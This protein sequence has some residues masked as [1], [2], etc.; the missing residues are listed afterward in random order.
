MLKPQYSPSYTSWRIGV[1]PELT[2]LVSARSR[3]QVAFSGQT[4]SY[5][6]W[7]DSVTNVPLPVVGGPLIVVMLSQYMPRVSFI[8]F[9]NTKKSGLRNDLH[10]TYVRSKRVVFQ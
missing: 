3:A 5:V 7:K 6:I 10:S 8:S 2:S 9:L 1:P 4:G